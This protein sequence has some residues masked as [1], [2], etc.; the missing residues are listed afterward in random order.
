MARIKIWNIN[1]KW[2]TAILGGDAKDSDGEDYQMNKNVK[3]EQT[4]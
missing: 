2:D 1:R 4:L 3:L